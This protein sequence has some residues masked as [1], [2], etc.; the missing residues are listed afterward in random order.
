MNKIKI[1]KIKE[2]LKRLFGFRKN[3]KQ[4]LEQSLKNIDE[5]FYKE[6]YNFQGQKL[7]LESLEP[8]QDNKN[9]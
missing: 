8:L 4:I 1:K 2:F 9:E 7:E 5:K 6:C 3:T